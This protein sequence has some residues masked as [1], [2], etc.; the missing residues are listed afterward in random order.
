MVY[1]L[2]LIGLNLKS[3]LLGFQARVRK[4]IFYTQQLEID[5]GGTLFRFGQKIP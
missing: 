3:L 2:L 5:F 1:I 4:G